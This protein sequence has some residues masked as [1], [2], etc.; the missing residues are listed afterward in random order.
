MMRSNKKVILGIAVILIISAFAYFRIAARIAAP[1][2]NEEVAAS[3]PVAPIAGARQISAEVIFDA[4]NDVQE[5]LRFTLDLDGSGAVIGAKTVDART[6]QA[7]EKQE[8]F[9]QGLFTIIKGKKLEELGPVDKI[10]TS[11]LTTK[12]FNDS[13]DELKAQL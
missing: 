8:A 13:L 6:G 12:A 11:S 10:G 4:P 2:K 7:S 1:V 9:S 3:Q 5:E